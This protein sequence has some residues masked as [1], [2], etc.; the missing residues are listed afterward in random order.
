MFSEPHSPFM[1]ARKVAKFAQR[2]IGDYIQDKILIAVVLNLMG[3]TRLKQ[4]RVAGSAFGPAVSPQTSPFQRFH[5]K[6]TTG[7]CTNAAGTVPY[8]LERD[9][10]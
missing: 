2:V 6:T 9:K 3:F 7:R 1:N 8:P 5:D 10:S 4:K